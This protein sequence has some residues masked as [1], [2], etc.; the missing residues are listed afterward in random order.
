[1]TARSP[2]FCRFADCGRPYSQ[3][4]DVPIVCP[5][6]QRRTTWTTAPSGAEF[7][8]ELRLSE[9]DRIFLRR[10]HILPES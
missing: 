3:P 9:N 1:M 6:C 5:A 10:H 7:S 4:G 8:P 2:L